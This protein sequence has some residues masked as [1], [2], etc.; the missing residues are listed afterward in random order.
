MVK[1]TSVVVFVLEEYEDSRYSTITS[2]VN[3]NV[4][5]TLEDAVSTVVRSYSKLNYPD[6]FAYDLT[7]KVVLNKIPSSEID[8]INE[9]LGE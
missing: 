5:T 4:F 1:Q 8:S 9:Q 7:N 2:I 3:A 6:I